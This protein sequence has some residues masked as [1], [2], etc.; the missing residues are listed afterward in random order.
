MT[1]D[2]ESV[3]RGGRFDCGSY[4]MWSVIELLTRLDLLRFVRVHAGRSEVRR[5]ERAGRGLIILAIMIS[6]FHSLLPI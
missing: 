6:P 1:S 4:W 5:G 2:D 3:L